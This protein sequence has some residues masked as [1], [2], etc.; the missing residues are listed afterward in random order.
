MDVS[1]LVGA[2]TEARRLLKAFRGADPGRARDAAARLCRLRGFA[3]GDPDAL[4]AQR[5]RVQLKHALTLIALELGFDSWAEF[6][7]AAA[8]R[9]EEVHVP[10]LGAMLNRWFADYREA[11]ASLEAEGGFLFPYRSQFFVCE[12]EGVRVMGFEPED[13]DWRRI[14]F[15][16]VRPRDRA[17]WERLCA[18]RRA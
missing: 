7:A 4:L 1:D 15:D 9:T 6:K 16:W 10:G 17:A 12:A 2:R 14:G 18:A 8:V 3:V 13:P 5:D 11:R